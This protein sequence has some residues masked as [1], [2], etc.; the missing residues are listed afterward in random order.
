MV[1]I[2]SNGE[3]IA[4][5]EEPRY[6]RKNETSGAYVRAQQEDAQGIAVLGEPYNLPGHTEIARTILKD[7]GTGET[8]TATAPEAY[9]VE[10]DGGEIAFGQDGKIAEV[11]ETST[12]G[13]LAVTDLYEQLVD[14]GVL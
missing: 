1:K 10:V 8:E 4:L 6:I 5:S 12:T 7:E 2:I 13:L 11:D 9:A 14:K 3:T